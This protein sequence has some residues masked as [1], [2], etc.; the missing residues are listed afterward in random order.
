VQKKLIDTS[1]FE[2]L[3]KILPR[4]ILFADVTTLGLSARILHVFQDQNIEYINKLHGIPLSKMLKWPKFGRGSLLKLSNNL[5]D[6]VENLGAHIIT[7]M[8]EFNSVP[9]NK[10]DEEFDTTN[11][12]D[13]RFDTVSSIPLKDHFLNALKNLKER[14]KQIIEFRTGYKGQV[15]TLEEIGGIFNLT[16]E[17]VRQLQKKYVNKIILT[18]Y[19]DDCIAIKIGQLLIDRNG[20]LYLEMLEIEDPWFEGFLGNYQHLTA[21]IELFSENEIRI[22]KN[23]GANIVTRIKQDDWDNCIC[24]IRRNL[25][26]KAGEALWSRSDIDMMFKASLVDKGAEELVGLIWDEFSSTLQFESNANDAKLIAYGKSAEVA[27]ET[28]LHQSEKPLHFSEFARRASELFGKP[29]EERLAH[30]ALPRLGA[31]LFG[32][33]IYGLEKFNPIPEKMA[34]NIK[35]V[36]EHMIISGPL[37]KQWHSSEITNKLKGK[38]SALPEE[39]DHYI[40]N[41]ILHN[42][43]KLIY[44]NRMVWARSDSNQSAENRIDMSD[45]FTKILED[46]GGPLKG[47]VIK[48]RLESIRG[49]Q[50][51]LQLQPSDRMIQVGPDYWGLIERDVVGTEEDRSSRLDTL[52]KHL[53]KAQKGIHVSEVDTLLEEFAYGNDGPSSYSLLNIAQRDKR[54]YLGRS[55]FLGLSEWG[56]DTRRVNISQAV[57]IILETMDKPLGINEINVRVQDLTG[58]EVDG[59]VTNTLINQGGVYNQDFF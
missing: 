40:L 42:S 14:D 1:N 30:N 16:R 29:I 9:N 2:K 46:N 49:V 54:F 25:K 13:Y 51:N 47:S 56:R 5:I 27:V 37:M 35:L 7:N 28:V 23:H 34:H 53:H 21:I 12:D 48:K 26:D 17:R 41:M 6:S 36:V 50:E 3:L 38:F 39:L 45:A 8:I 43:N 18:E 15:K 44:L 22:I 59:T 55:M 52:Y 57:R 33:G 58:L 4:N 10:S 31:K 19:W 24:D 11:N 20:P 32:R